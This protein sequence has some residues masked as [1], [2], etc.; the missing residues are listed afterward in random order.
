MADVNPRKAYASPL[1]ERQAALT[2]RAVLDAA[3]ELFVDRGYTA[4]TIDAIADRAGV[5]KPTVFSAVGNKQTLLKTLRDVAFTGDEAPAAV[6]DRPHVEAI[7][8]EP[9]RRRAVELIAKHLTAVAGRY[10]ELH[11]VL[12]A[13][14]HGSDKELRDLWEAE[15][16]EGLAGAGFWVGILAE[17]G[18]LPAGMARRAAVDVMWLLM[19]PDHY[20]RLVHQRGWSQRRYE[21]WLADTIT[22]LLLD[23]GS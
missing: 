1:R 13:A 10:A 7:R 20:Y 14:A 16:R 19:T 23:E 15:Q 8:A 3:R 2:R 6:R 21:S 22:R 4:T 9:D 5:S 11:E 18:P 17:K 12:R